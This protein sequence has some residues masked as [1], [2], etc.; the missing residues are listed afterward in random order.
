M[1]K[2]IS[3]FCLVSLGVL[4]SFRPAPFFDRPQSPYWKKNVEK[5]L[6][7]MG[8][9]ENREAWVY[10]LKTYL[11]AKEWHLLGLMARA[12]INDGMNISHLEKLA[13]G[14]RSI[15]FTNAVQA[16]KRIRALSSDLDMTKGEL[17][18]MALFLE[19]ELDKALASTGNYLSRKKTGFGCTIEHDPVTKMTFLHLNSK[20]IDALGKGVKKQVTRSIR[21]DSKRPEM[22]ACCRTSIPLPTEIE[23]LNTMKEA[24]GIVKLYATTERLSKDNVKIYTLFCELYRGGSLSQSLDKKQRFSFKQKLDIAHQL[25]TGLEEL[26]EQKLIHRDLTTRN[27]LL[28]YD[29]VGKRRSRQIKAVLCDLG[30]TIELEKALAVKPQAN[31]AYMPPEG[32]IYE[33]LEGKDYFATDIYALGCVFTSFY[34]EKNAPGST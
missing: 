22:V 29:K 30:R 28:D 2:W 32:I 9:K 19:T 10:T 4:S 14:S 7:R 5:S 3:A 18:R 11:D 17:F 16:T 15:P 13:E 31:M 23:A 21:Y 6:P 26:H 12:A 27:V 1:K 33:K 24:K 8:D 25:L 20:G 34:R